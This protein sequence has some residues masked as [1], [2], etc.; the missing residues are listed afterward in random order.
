MAREQSAYLAD[1]AREARRAQDFVAG[2]DW[3]AFQ[4]DVRLQ[5]AVQHALLIVGEAFSKLEP[6]HR[7]ALTDVPIRQIIGMRNRVAHEYWAVDP[8]VV[9]Q[10]ATEDL[11]PL[12]KAV[13]AL[14]DV[15]GSG[16]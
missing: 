11:A 14:A 6:E 5:Y 8:A 9:W 13:E 2:C 7:Q 16:G 4:A 1:I 3:P 12:L 15:T 10:V